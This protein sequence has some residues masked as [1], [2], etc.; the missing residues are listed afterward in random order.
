MGIRDHQIFFANP[1]DGLRN[2]NGSVLKSSSCQAGPPSFFAGYAG[3]TKPPIVL[4]RRAIGPS[5]RSSAIL[6]PFRRTGTS[7]FGLGR[8]PHFHKP[9]FFASY[10]RHSF[11][12][13]SQ[14]ERQSAPQVF[15]CAPLKR[16][17]PLGGLFFPN[18][19]VA[20]R[21]SPERS[22]CPL[23][24]LSL[25]SELRRRLFLF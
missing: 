16:W 21:V 24:F 9:P 14:S 25:R 1:A 17:P 23:V 5:L 7:I 12:F 19:L 3:Y 15:R 4:P 2:A 13:S 10:F 11:F 8:V 18:P 20:N 6:F 22:S